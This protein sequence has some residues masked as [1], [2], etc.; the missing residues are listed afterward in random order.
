MLDAI[1]RSG[2]EAGAAR[3][4]GRLVAR[5]ATLRAMSISVAGMLQAGAT[6]LQEAALIK[7]L[8]VDLEQ[9]MPRLVEELV[10]L[11]P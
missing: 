11:P 1:G 3:D 9:D 7:D 5:L 10:G 6:P 2:F 4:V 8:G